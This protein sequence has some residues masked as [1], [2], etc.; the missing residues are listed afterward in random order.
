MN[1]ISHE[2]YI[3]QLKC[4]KLRGIFKF[5]SSESLDANGRLFC[6]IFYAI[7]NVNT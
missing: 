4:L 7:K 5:F 1:G 3:G 6:S 2:N